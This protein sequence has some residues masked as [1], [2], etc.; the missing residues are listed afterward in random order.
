MACPYELPCRLY[1]HHGIGAKAL[2]FDMTKTLAPLHYFRLTDPCAALLS[3]PNTTHL[4]VV[5][6]VIVVD[7]DVAIIIGVE[8]PRVAAI[9][10]VDGSALSLIPHTFWRSTQSFSPL[11]RVQK[12]QLQTPRFR[13]SG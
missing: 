2:S 1:K 13:E 7:F 8:I 4:I 3:L 12:S 11:P 5:V 9:I 10:G 6:S